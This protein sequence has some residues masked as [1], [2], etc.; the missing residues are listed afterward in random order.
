[1]T[2]ATLEA[3]RALCAAVPELLVGAGTVLTPEQADLARDAG[4]DFAL[5]PGLDVPTVRHCGASGIPFVPG[6][7]TPSDIQAALAAGC[8]LLKF[9]PAEPLGGARGLGILAAPFAHLGVTYLPLGG[10]DKENVSAYLKVPE[11]LPW[12]APGLH[13]AR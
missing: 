9:F 2:P 8:R 10:I 4:A 13:H 3:L 7:A 6:I 11:S 5:A 12:A 1:M